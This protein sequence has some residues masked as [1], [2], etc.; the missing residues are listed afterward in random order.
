MIG[1]LVEKSP[2]KL[3]LL[4][5]ETRF[6]A[7]N[8]PFKI[9]ENFLN[10]NKICILVTAGKPTDNRFSLVFVQNASFRAQSVG[11]LSRGGKQS[12]DHGIC[13]MPKGAGQDRWI[14]LG[15]PKGPASLGGKKDKRAGI[16]WRNEG[17]C[18]NYSIAHKPIAIS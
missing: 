8:L 6:L 1:S 14:E 16:R 9:F 13:G 15:C 18:R 17:N 10:I 11:I 7:Q 12:M 5:S 3:L 2:T 4:P